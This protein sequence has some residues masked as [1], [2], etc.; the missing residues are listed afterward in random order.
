MTGLYNE[1]KQVARNTFNEITIADG[2]DLHKRE[3]N[4]IL[5][6]THFFQSNFQ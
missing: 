6:F 2:T 5:A 1:L 4:I 3:T